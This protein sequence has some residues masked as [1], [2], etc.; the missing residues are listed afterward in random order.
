MTWP[1]TVIVDV[2]FIPIYLLLLAFSIFN[3]VKHGTGKVF[4]FISICIFSAVRLVG[5]SLLVYVY[6]DHYRH[7]NAATWGFILQALGYSFLVNATLALYKRAAIIGNPTK[8]AQ[9]RGKPLDMDRILH[10]V[11]L[12]ALILLITGYNDSDVFSNSSSSSMPSSPSSTSLDGKAKAG[13]LIYVGLTVFIAVL[14]SYRLFFRGSKGDEPR[15]I[16]SFIL[17]ALPFMLCRAV[18]AAVKAFSDDAL[19][20]SLWAKVVFDYIAEVIVVV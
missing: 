1:A 5:N 17:G 6:N 4:G 3:V 10:L 14:C 13:D 15:T 20:G 8:A 18:Y 9:L 11:T 16:L 19:Q 12:G 7:Q 2:V